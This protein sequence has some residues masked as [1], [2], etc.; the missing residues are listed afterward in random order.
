MICLPNPMPD[1]ER[2]ADGVEQHARVVFESH[3]P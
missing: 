1:Q 3:L 2:T